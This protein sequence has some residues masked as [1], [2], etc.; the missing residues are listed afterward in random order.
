MNLLAQTLKELDGRERYVMERRFGLGST[1]HTLQQI[2]DML[3]LTHERVRQI[4]N[5]TV[6]RMRAVID[7]A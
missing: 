5:A 2:G 3:G 1:P 6:E 4:Q 7:A